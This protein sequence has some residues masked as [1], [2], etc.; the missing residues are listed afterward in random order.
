M[1]LGGWDLSYVR[2]AY[3]MCIFLRMGGFEA[4]I[5]LLWFR[6]RMAFGREGRVLGF[7]G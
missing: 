3:L 6:H 2:T 5:Y 1:Y 7:G 4:Y